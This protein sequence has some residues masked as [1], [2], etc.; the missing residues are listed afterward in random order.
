M[1]A[2]CFMTNTAAVFALAVALCVLVCT[3]VQHNEK[4]IPPRTAFQ[5][6]SQDLVPKVQLA[7]VPLGGGRFRIAIETEAFQFTDICLAHAVAAPIGH[8]HLQVN[9]VKVASVYQPVAEVGPLPPGEHVID[10]VL[11]GQ[12][13]RALVSKAGLL[14][15]EVAV[16]V[17]A[18]PT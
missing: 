8:A 14:K 2:R 16:I 4:G 12:D 9:G 13:H 17:V 5:V 11:R 6:L 7:A 1:L 3:A 18:E 15:A 10:V